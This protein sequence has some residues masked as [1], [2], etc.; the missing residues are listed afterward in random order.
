MRALPH[1]T[2]ESISD[3]ELG[4]TGNQDPT[5]APSG[6]YKTKDQ[7][8]LALAVCSDRQF[9]GFCRALGREDPGSKF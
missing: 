4:R 3:E 6:I 5:A 7:R 9:Q 2:Y 8:F 1:F